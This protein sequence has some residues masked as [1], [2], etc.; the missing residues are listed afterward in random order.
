MLNLKFSKAIFASHSLLLIVAPTVSY[1]HPKQSGDF[2]QAMTDS[3]FDFVFDSSPDSTSTS[4]PDS[5]SDQ[6]VPLNKQAAQ[7]AKLYIQKNRQS[8][9]SIKQRNTATFAMMETVLRKYGLPVELKYLAV[10]ESELK[11]TARSRVG[12]VGPWQF[13]PS[14]A[15]ILGLKVTRKN[16]ER[17][18]YE[19]ST[20]AAAIYLKDLYAEYGDWLLVIAAYNSGPAPVN[21][22]IRKSGSRNF[23]KLQQ[24]L[25]AETRGHVKKFIATHYYF[26]GQGGVTTF[27]KAEHLS[28]IKAMIELAAKRE[29]LKTNAPVEGNPGSTETTT[30]KAVAF[31]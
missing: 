10:V 15:K 8:L 24:F 4:K 11:S 1:E 25:P 18:H 9:R 27:T 17:K 2:S 22:A 20:K 21:R 26:E 19:K 30:Q 3:D 14:T 23:W 29:Q 5:C 7:F 31:N 16:D 13:M 6:K 28:Y 12:A